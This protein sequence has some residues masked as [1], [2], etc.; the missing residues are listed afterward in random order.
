MIQDVKPVTQRSHLEDLNVIESNLV[1][2]SMQIS[3][4]CLKASAGVSKMQ[5]LE[6]RAWAERQNVRY[7]EQGLIESS[8][9]L[10]DAAHEIEHLSSEV[11][12][13][14]LAMKTK[15]L[16]YSMAVRCEIW[17]PHLGFWR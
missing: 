15:D 9:A 14:A 7:L 10:K 11:R 3:R 12:S 13:Y 1:D 16:F 5:N 6:R 2:I 8:Q 4:V 17:R